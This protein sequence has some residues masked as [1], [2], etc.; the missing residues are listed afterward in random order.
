MYRMPASERSLVADRCK[1]LL[2][3]VDKTGAKAVLVYMNFNDECYLLD[4]PSQ[5]KELDKLG[6]PS[7]D[8][9]LQKVPMINREAVTEKISALIKAAKQ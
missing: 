3:N 1:T 5:K 7:V 4:Y 9:T 2:E 8:I 6:I